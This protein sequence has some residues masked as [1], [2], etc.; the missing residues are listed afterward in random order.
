MKAYE[1]YGHVHNIHPTYSW[2]TPDN[3]E[4]MSKA[5]DFE[6]PYVIHNY[7]DDEQVFHSIRLNLLITKLKIIH[8]DF[9][10]KK[11]EEM[12][13]LPNNAYVFYSLVVDLNQQCLDK[14]KEAHDIIDKNTEK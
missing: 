4:Y 10:F 1:V 7:M 3:L 6:P 13:A 2:H 9:V 12:G 14:Y 5:L 8:S 11:L